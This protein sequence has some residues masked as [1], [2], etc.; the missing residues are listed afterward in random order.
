[1]KFS[2]GFA[3]LESLVSGRA[4]SVETGALL[5]VHLASVILVRLHELSCAFFGRI[6]EVWEFDDACKAVDD[7][8]REVG[9]NR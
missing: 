8:M 2:R 5:L 1:M 3:A 6:M 7:L 4:R 9:V